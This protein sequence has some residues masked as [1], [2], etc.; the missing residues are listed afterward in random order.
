VSYSIPSHSPLSL[1]A[2]LVKEVGDA[3]LLNATGLKGEP[4]IVYSINLALN[5]APY[6]H[7]FEVIFLYI[8]AV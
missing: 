1:Y 2:L 6:T 7:P 8:L 5:A 4:I 3:G